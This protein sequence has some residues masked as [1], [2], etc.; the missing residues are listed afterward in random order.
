VE[1][2][3]LN[4]FPVITMPASSRIFRPANRHLLLITLI[5]ATLLPAILP[6]RATAAT[7][8]VPYQRGQ[9]VYILGSHLDI[10][11]DKAGNLTI[12]EISAPELAGKFFPSPNEK[13]NWGFSPSVF[14]ARFSAAG[15]FDPDQQ[16]LLELDYSLLDH[17]DIYLPR[18]D[19]SYLLKKSGDLL[20]FREREIQNRNLLVSLPQSAL[21]GSP[22][23]LRIASGSTI[24]LPMTI[25]SAR[26]FLKSDHNEQF[27]L[28]IYYGIILL[29]IV[30]SLLLLITLREISY[31]YHLLF[32]VN[33]GMFQIIMNGTAYEYLWPDRA[34]WNSQCLPL[35]IGLSCLGIAL[36]SRKFLETTTTTPKLDQILRGIA[37]GSVIIASLPFF[38]SY[39]T[40]IRLAAGTSLVT[41]I[42]IIIC[43]A[44]R[45]GSG[46]RPARYFMAAWSLFFLGIIV[47]V[48]RAFGL[49]N[50]DLIYL[51]GPQVGS[52]L[53]VILLALALADRIKIT[54]QHNA[55]AQE[56]YR[57]LFENSTEGM[58]RVSPTGKIIMVNPALAEMFGYSSPSELLAAD[59]AIDKTSADAGS[60]ARLRAELLGH[61]VIRNFET[62]M[63]RKDHNLLTVLINAYSIRDQKGQI[64]YFEG[65][66]AD[67]TERK[68]A[69]EMC[70]AKET[71]ESA[72][73]AKSK[74]LATMSHEIRTPMN[75]VVGL[76]NLLLDMDVPQEFRKYLEMIKSSSDRLLTI[77][78]DILDFSRIETGHL[79]LEK[80]GFSLEDHLTPSLQILA[81]KAREKQLALNWQFPP[82][83]ARPLYG[84]PNRL[85][86]I[87]VNLVA[88]AIK[89]TESGRIDLTIAA[90]SSGASQVVL[91]GAVRDTGIGIRADQKELIFKEFTQADSSTARKFGGSGLGLAIATELA[92]LMDGRIWVEETPEEAPDQTGSIFRFSVVLGLAPGAPTPSR[93]ATPAGL[94]NHQDRLSILLA[95]DEKINRVLTGA[96]LK[97]RGWLVGEAENGREVLARLSEQDY[98][99]V[100]M[101]LEMPEMDGLEATCLI[102]A[103][104]QAS[105]RHLPIIAMTAHAVAGYRQICL[106]AGMDDYIS[107]PFEINDLLEVMAKYVPRLGQGFERPNQPPAPGATGASS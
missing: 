6:P 70:I 28:G 60:N 19:G 77:I 20:P 48:L 17:V 97:R 22:I 15:N 81:L 46:D 9:E 10:L 106:E 103:G 42:T 58:F 21:T 5:L 88:N 54:E 66:L 105:G 43:G 35:F 94:Q 63:H 84:D 65:M 27:L 91:H 100:L 33:F 78:N 8:P 40:A 95:D 1:T 64:L 56:R 23:Y 68:K 45:I 3:Q 14:W 29:V 69:E 57:S 102:R 31:L 55:E 107:K 37:I 87:I 85:N 53:T 74:F 38:C 104:E 61:G 25:W 99:L 4:N 89:F 18:A 90:E 86:Q 67:I 72:N 41:I 11:E 59:L 96:I 75:G 47:M 62:R 71:A 36:F 101:D 82:D 39:R 34:N 50:N 52:A 30:Y 13:P 32:I 7:A 26:A 51:Y 79:Q 98:D 2:T 49:L 24:S 16:W 12:N 73:R 80:I 92:K 44:I 83:L 93:E 76:T